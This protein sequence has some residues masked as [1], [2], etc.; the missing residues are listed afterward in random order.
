MLA[1]LIPLHVALYVDFYWTKSVSSNE[2]V[3]PSSRLK[4]AELALQPTCTSA[5]MERTGKMS[6]A[7]MTRP[8]S[9]RM[10]PPDVMACPEPV[11]AGLSRKRCGVRLHRPMRNVAGE[12]HL[13]LRSQSGKGCGSTSGRISTLSPCETPIWLGQSSMAGTGRF[14]ASRRASRR[15]RASGALQS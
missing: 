10:F 3:L 13:D 4:A 2:R 14:D 15:M 12:C 6:V 1:P 5:S 9:M 7:M 11:K 8:R